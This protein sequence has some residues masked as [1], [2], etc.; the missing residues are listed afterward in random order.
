[1]RSFDG[2]QVEL[3][4]RLQAAEVVEVR[5]ALGDRAPVREQAAEP[6][7]RDVRHADTRRVLRDGVLRLLLRADE[8][9][10]P[11]ALG[12]VARELVRLL[13]QLLRLREVDDVDPAA[14]AE[15]VAAHLGIPATRL[16][17]EVDAGLQ[18]LSHRDD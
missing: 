11:A 3:A 10:R 12:D 15:D 8:E 18:Q 4:V 1:M 14:L 13:E 5:D 7:V 2:Q 16:V 17:A 9:D 6:A